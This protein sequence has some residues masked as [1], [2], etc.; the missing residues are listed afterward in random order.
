MNNLRILRVGAGEV[1]GWVGA[2]APPLL[3][4]DSANLH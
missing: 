3:E 4:Y 2:L 1:W